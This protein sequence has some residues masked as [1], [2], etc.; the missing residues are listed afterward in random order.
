M[1]ATKS[2]CKQTVAVSA[3]ES[4]NKPALL[5]RLAIL[6][7]CLGAALVCAALPAKAQTPGTVALVPNPVNVGQSVTVVYT[8]GSCSPDNAEFKLEDDPSVTLDGFCIV[9]MSPNADGTWSGTYCTTEADA[10][11]DS[12]TVTDGSCDDTIDPTNLTVVELLDITAPYASEDSQW[13]DQ[14]NDAD[15]DWT[16]LK[17][18]WSGDYVVLGLDI[19]P[20]NAVAASLIDWC[21]Y[22]TPSS[23]NLWASFP[24]GSVNGPL[25]IT[26]SQD[27]SDPPFVT[28]PITIWIFWVEISYNFGNPLDDDDQLTFSNTNFDFPL[29]T[30][31]R[32]TGPYTDYVKNTRNGQWYYVAFNKMEIIGTLQPAGIGSVISNS[33]TFTF[34]DQYINFNAWDTSSDPGRYSRTSHEYVPDGGGSGFVSGVSQQVM[35]VHDKIFAIDNPGNNMNE[36]V[37]QYY[38]PYNLTAYEG[39]AADFEDIVFINGANNID[40]SDLAT[41]HSFDQ[42]AFASAN[43]ITFPVNHVGTSAPTLPTTWNGNPTPW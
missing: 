37:C 15:R 7:L 36:G 6:A 34:S 40:A 16:V 3:E 24:A 13:N 10:G 2:N 26:A 25:P 21:R 8:P 18:P 19:L 4:T 27:G 9:P 30:N 32:N 38:W 12:I 17:S 33:L 28:D 29:M 1:K 43:N 41:W 11:T 14:I 31:P 35:P 20:D 39:Q 23:D 5:R 22:V 42:A